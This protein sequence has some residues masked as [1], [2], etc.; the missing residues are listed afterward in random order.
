MKPQSGIEV[1]LNMKK[2][3]LRLNFLRYRSKKSPA[4]GDAWH[5]RKNQSFGA[6]LQDKNTSFKR[7]G[8]GLIDCPIETPSSKI[9]SDCLKE[10]IHSIYLSSMAISAVSIGSKMSITLFEK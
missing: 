10:L 1:L 4:C 7:I 3:S 9:T 6:H 8:D 5:K 2:N